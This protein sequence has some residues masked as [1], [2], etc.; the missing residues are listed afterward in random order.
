MMSCLHYCEVV[1]VKETGH[2]DVI[3]LFLCELVLTI[4]PITSLPR[5]SSSSEKLSLVSTRVRTRGKSPQSFVITRLC[6][7]L[8][9][10]IDSLSADSGI[11]SHDQIWAALLCL[12]HYR[13]LYVHIHTTSICTRSLQLY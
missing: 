7:I 6:N 5:Q 13:C 9:D 3:L 10:A 1:V 11:H 8:N 2:F 4:H 12:S